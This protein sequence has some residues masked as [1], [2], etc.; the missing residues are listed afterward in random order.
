MHYRIRG[1]NV[2]LVKTVTDPAT[3]KARSVPVGSANL[4]SGALNAKATESL[5]AEE[6][7]TVSEWI[8]QRKEIQDRQQALHALTLPKTLSEVAGWVKGADKAEVEAVAEDIVFA[9]RDL[10]RMI[11]RK[12]KDEATAAAA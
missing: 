11:E 7:A 9:M 6:V 5:T 4:L 12:L 1:N 10:R 2:Q 3:N 8:R